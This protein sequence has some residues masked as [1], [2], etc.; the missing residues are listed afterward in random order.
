MYVYLYV[1]MHIDLITFITV[2]YRLSGKSG[3]SRAQTKQREQ[4]SPRCLHRG[5]ATV[6]TRREERILGRWVTLEKGFGEGSRSCSSVFLFAKG[7]GR[8]MCLPSREA[9]AGGLN[10]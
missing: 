1:H 3:A 5:A 8:R 9:L 10:W 6:S 7:C 2:F 4:T